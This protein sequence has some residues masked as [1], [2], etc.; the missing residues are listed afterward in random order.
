M[1]VDPLEWRGMYQMNHDGWVGKLHITLDD[2]T[3]TNQNGQQFPGS[4]VL[5]NQGGQHMR[6]NIRFPG[7]TQTFDAYMFSWDKKKM[8]GITYWGGQIFGFY[9]FK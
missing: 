7:N 4:L 2:V 3:Y 1:V 8:A 6:F 5:W 9:A